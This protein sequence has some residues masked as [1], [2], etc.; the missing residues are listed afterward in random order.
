M[1]L[2]VGANTSILFEC[3]SEALFSKDF[4]TVALGR[5]IASV[6]HSGFAADDS[7]L[8]EAHVTTAPETNASLWHL[9]AK[10]VFECDWGYQDNYYV[11][12][13]G[14][15][16]LRSPYK[17]A[18]GDSVPHRQYQARVVVTNEGWLAGPKLSADIYLD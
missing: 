16:K 15:T 3:G 12:C 2:A 5:R 1:C 17:I 14:T 9:R 10:I 6:S 11:F 8:S 13:K 7:L 18:L 4:H